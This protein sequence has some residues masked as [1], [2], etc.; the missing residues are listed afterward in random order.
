MTQASALSRLEKLAEDEAVKR[1]KESY[2]YGD[3]SHEERRAFE[4]GA[5]FAGKSMLALLSEPGG[6]CGPRVNVHKD[7]QGAMFVYALSGK[8]WGGGPYEPTEYVPLTE[9]LQARAAHEV[10]RQRLQKTIDYLAEAVDERDIALGKSGIEQQLGTANAALAS[11]EARVRI[12][13][14]ALE[15]YARGTLN[16]PSVAQEALLEVQR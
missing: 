12:L 13:S 2:G 15:F 10:E 3:T 14:D 9:L 16:G 6:A 7:G 8:S 11:S 4:C 1:Y 5:E